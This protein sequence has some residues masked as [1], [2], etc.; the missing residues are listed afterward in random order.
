MKDRDLH[1]ETQ[2]LAY[3]LHQKRGMVHGFDLE[4]WLEAERTIL[5]KYAREIGKEIGKTSKKKKKS[6]PGKT[7]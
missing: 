7:Q 1:A 3:E 2:K 5:E 6:S 4:D